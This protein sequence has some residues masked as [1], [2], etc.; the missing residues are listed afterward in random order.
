M[1]F[2][3]IAILIIYFLTISLLIFGFGKVKTTTSKDF[4]PQTNFSIIVPFR[5]EESNVLELLNSVAG[6]D[7]PKNLYEIVVIN[8]DS[9][10]NSVSI[11]EKWVLENPAIQS[12]LCQNIRKSNSP[13]K[14]AIATAVIKIQDN[15]IITTDADC[16]VNKNWLLAFDNLIQNSIFEMIAAP[17]SI[18]NKKGFLNYFQ[19]IDLLS[20]QGTTIGTFGL[21]KPFMC[22]GAN[23]AY[24]K[25]LF[26]EL[27]GFEG[28]DKIA[29]G[30]DVFLLQKALKFYP[31]K[32]AYLKNKDAIVFTKPEKNWSKLFTQRVRWAS[33]TDSYDGFF[34]KFLA[35]IVL[36]TNLA[37]IIGIFILNN[38]FLIGIFLIKFVIDLILLIK[39]NRFISDQKFLFPIISGLF[40]PFFCVSVAFY[41]FFGGFE[42]K[43]RK[44]KQ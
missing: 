35:V 1:I 25:K 42:W 17:V 43:N 20:L 10:D 34:E 2:F 32:V 36:L 37:I 6:L 44:F 23:F 30:D 31:N 18:L 13:K 11:F 21:K 8:D 39:T 9:T 19:F 28:N 40:Y 38:K 29:S 3:F 41:S 27:N 4:Q 7:Y 14:D 24:T 16:V 15:W 5:N 12:R 26:L 33:K 22:N